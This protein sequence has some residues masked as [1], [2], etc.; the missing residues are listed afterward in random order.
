MTAG[1]VGQ[2]SGDEPTKKAMTAGSDRWTTAL[3]I[4]YG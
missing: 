3:T 1:F 4:K 2:T